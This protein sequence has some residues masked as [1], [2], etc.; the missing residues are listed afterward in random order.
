MGT[1]FNQAT[2]D[3][4]TKLKQ[5]SLSFAVSDFTTDARFTKL[6]R[7]VET[8]LQLLQKKNDDDKK[9]E[10]I[11]DLD[12]DNGND[13]DNPM[14]LG[15]VKRPQFKTAPSSTR[16]KSIGRKYKGKMVETEEAFE[17]ESAY[18]SEA[19]ADSTPKQVTETETPMA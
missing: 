10:K 7:N 4:H 6:E 1:V 15:P 18:E 12:D 5:M 16:K 8:I 11:V 13:G 9:G 3:L 14:S 19:E 17:T 2:S